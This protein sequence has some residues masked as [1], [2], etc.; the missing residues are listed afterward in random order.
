MF[1]LL[2]EVILNII[3]PIIVMSTFHVIMLHYTGGYCI[4]IYF[5]SRTSTFSNRSSFLEQEFGDLS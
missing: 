5:R 4:A 1:L 3:S 2:F